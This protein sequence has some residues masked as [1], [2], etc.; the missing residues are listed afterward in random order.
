MAANQ[1][2][3]KLLPADAHLRPLSLQTLKPLTSK[4]HFDT[5]G[6]MTANEAS[7]HP[8]TWLVAHHDYGDHGDGAG[9]WPL[10][11]GLPSVSFE[12][13]KGKVVAGF[14]AVR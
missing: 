10:I 5:R 3:E 12:G 9:A 1:P 11:H 8:V 14:S 13:N 6:S 7:G 2:Q 4:P